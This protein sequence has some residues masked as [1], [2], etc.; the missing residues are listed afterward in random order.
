MK[1]VENAVIVIHCLQKID[2]VENTNYFFDLLIT[3]EIWL[4]PA[5]CCFYVP[6]MRPI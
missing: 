3:Q 4:Y 6:L 2:L 1:S 5:N